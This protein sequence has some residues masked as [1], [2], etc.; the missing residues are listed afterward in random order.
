MCIE[1]G[2]YKK[3]YA[4]VKRITPYS[5]LVNVNGVE[6]CIKKTS[7]KICGWQEEAGG[8]INHFKN[9]VQWEFLYFPNKHRLLYAQPQVIQKLA[10]FV[11]L[12]TLGLVYVI[13]HNYLVYIIPLF[14]Q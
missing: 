14:S 4:I 1:C 9:T 5:V 7:V 8:K 12:D 3:K 13:P 10:T 11:A 6:R 2:E